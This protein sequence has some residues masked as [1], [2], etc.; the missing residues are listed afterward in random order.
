MDFVA[1]LRQFLLADQFSLKVVFD[2]IRNSI[3]AATVISGGVWVRSYLKPPFD[4]IPL[5]HDMRVILGRLL[6]FVGFTLVA[7]NLAQLFV[8]HIRA[9][10]FLRTQAKPST[11][12]TAPTGGVLAILL[13]GMVSFF[14][15]FA[16][17]AILLALQ[18]ATLGLAMLFALRTVGEVL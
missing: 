13:A 17:I 14:I 4:Q 15:R 8:M 12:D 1:K 10:E 3:I 18:F 16:V 5:D 2:N 6:L 11:D 7:L 9:R